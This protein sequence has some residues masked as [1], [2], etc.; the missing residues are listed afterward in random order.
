MFTT[1]TIHYV[2]HYHQH[3]PPQEPNRTRT[4]YIYY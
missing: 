4:N 2:Y 3:A 1:S